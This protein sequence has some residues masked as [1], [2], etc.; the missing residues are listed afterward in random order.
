MLYITEPHQYN[1]IAKQELFQS[2]T[3]Y[4]SL[5]VYSILSQSVPGEIWIDTF[6]N[7]TVAYIYDLKTTHI[8][9][10]DLIGNKDHLLNFINTNVKHVVSK[11]RYGS[12][13]IYRS[14]WDFINDYTKLDFLSHANVIN[15]RIYKFCGFKNDSWKDMIPKGFI[16]TEVT[17]DIIKMDLK[18]ISSL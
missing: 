15:R 2:L 10:G 9:I 18:N 17:K 5:L 14:E 12:K 1:L 13:L 11:N 8:L 16:F 6:D 3:N 7:P 4:T